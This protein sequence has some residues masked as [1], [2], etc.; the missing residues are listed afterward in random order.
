MYLLGLAAWLTQLI[1][2]SLLQLLA[3]SYSFSSPPPSRFIYRKSLFKGKE[4]RQKT[5]DFEFFLQGHLSNTGTRSEQFCL[6]LTRLHCLGIFCFLSTL[7]ISHREEKPLTYLHVYPLRKS[8]HAINMM[9]PLETEKNLL[10]IG[11]NKYFNLKQ[12]IRENFNNS[13]PK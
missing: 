11:K 9:I 6:I 5:V 2:I 12:K 13:Y 1:C 3:A 8:L 4:C 7:R 10:F